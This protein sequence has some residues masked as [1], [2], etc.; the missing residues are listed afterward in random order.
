MGYLEISRVP[1]Q[2]EVEHPAS[3][4]LKTHLQGPRGRKKQ[5]LKSVRASWSLFYQF[6]PAKELGA[7]TEQD[8]EIR[9]TGRHGCWES[10]RTKLIGVTMMAQYFY[11][12][13]VKIP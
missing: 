10:N 6:V 9:G 8:V 12:I 2:Y 7:N 5:R 3:K 11:I 1:R 13:P 4:P